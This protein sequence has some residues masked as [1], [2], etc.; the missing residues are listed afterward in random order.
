MTTWTDSAA[1]VAISVA[2]GIADVRLTRADKMNALDPAMFDG[3]IAAIDWLAGEGAVRAVVLSGEGRGFCAG[4]DMGS[5]ASGGAGAGMSLTDRPHGLANS[6]QQVAWGWR[7]LPVPVIAAVHGVA[8]GGGFQ[9]MSGADIRIAHPDTRLAIMELKWGLVPDMAGLPL[10]RGNIRDDH[11]RELAYTAREFTADEGV[12][13]GA[14]TRLSDDPHAAAMLLAQA[15]AGRNPDAIR[16]MKRL[17]N[18]LYEDSAADLLLAESEE[19]AAVM[20]TPNQIEAVM[21]NFEKRVPKFADGSVVAA[22]AVPGFA[23]EGLPAQ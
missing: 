21:A 5:M 16:G 1:R 13:Y 18:A 11:L 15:I 19:Q 10:W 6:F 8:L 22:R 9:I 4:L 17:A 23:D 3:I 14:I 7:T 20:R 12:G 2:D